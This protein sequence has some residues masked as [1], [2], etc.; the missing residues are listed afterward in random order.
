MKRNYTAEEMVATFAGKAIVKPANGY[1]LV[2]TSDA[3]SEAEM[4]A[5]CSK[6]VYMEIC[7]IIR[8]SN[9]RS[10]KCPHL[11]E[12]R[13]CRPGVPAIK[14]VGNPLFTDVQIPKTMVYR[15]GTKVLEIRANP[16]LNISSIKALNTLCPECVIRRQP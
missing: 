13:S 5:V 7:I 16:L 12:L 3:V 4:N 15:I 2:M 8:N 1:M 14:I 6:A 11:R 10:L 9:F